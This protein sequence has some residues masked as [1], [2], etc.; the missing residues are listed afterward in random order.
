[1]QT[2]ISRLFLRYQKCFRALCVKLLEYRRFNERLAGEEEM[3][4]REFI[5]LQ[6]IQV[7]MQIVQF[8]IHFLIWMGLDLNGCK[9]I[10][11]H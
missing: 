6:I 7:F 11:R 3:L 1:M 4:I 8:P 5:S 9:M 10:S 2:S